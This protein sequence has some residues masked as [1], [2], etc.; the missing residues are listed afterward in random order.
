MIQIYYESH[1]TCPLDPNFKGGVFLID[2]VGMQ[3][4]T[5]CQSIKTK[6][7]RLLD[8]IAQAEGFT[9]LQAGILFLLSMEDAT[10]GDVSAATGMGQANTS[11]LCKKL[12]QAG[13]LI[14]T[15]SPEDGR[16]VILSLTEKGQAATERWRQRMERLMA[17]FANLPQEVK[18]DCERGVHAIEQALD[19]VY[20]QSKG[21]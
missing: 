17:L 3:I 8:P 10:V 5:I 16:V 6:S 9:S 14:R 18:D 20:E 2:P 15:R 7:D 19:Y 4:L 12:E 21:E 11:A 1:I 13:L